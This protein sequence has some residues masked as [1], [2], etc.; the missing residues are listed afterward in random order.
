MADNSF[1]HVPDLHSYE[2]NH[3]A[4]NAE[5][6]DVRSLP[7]ILSDLKTGEGSAATTAVGQLTE[8]V[9]SG[10]QCDVQ[11]LYEG[12]PQCSCCI[13]WVEEYPKN[14]KSC[15]E[16]E[17]ETKKKALIVRMAKNHREGRQLALDS[18]VVQNQQIKDLLSEVFQGYQGITPNLKRLVLKAPFHPFFHRWDV[19]KTLVAEQK[20]NGTEAAPFSHLLYR[21]LDLETTDTRDEIEDLQSKGVITYQLL[22]A[23]FHPGMQIY[24]SMNGH[25]RIYLM[26]SSQYQANPWGSGLSLTLKSV[27]WDG[28]EFGFATEHI[29]VSEFSGTMKINELSAYPLVYHES[30]LDV[31]DALKHRGEKFFSLKGVHHKAYSG[32]LL[33]K[34]R[35]NTVLKVSPKPC[36]MLSFGISVKIM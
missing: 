5:M 24:A 33:R 8:I 18:I 30:R 20:T 6:P 22:W 23:L 29:F 9:D 36:C 32:D 28:K 31:M 1:Y 4:V 35:Q 19:F 34:D 15:I 16:Q 2:T 13:N 25:D 27:D 11:M 21:I 3:E 14:L 17:A 10:T 26:E 7:D 12:P